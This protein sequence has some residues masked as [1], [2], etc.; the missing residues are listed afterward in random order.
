MDGCKP[1]LSWGKLWCT[2]ILSVSSWTRDYRLM[3]CCRQ[4]SECSVRQQQHCNLQWTFAQWYLLL[5]R[6]VFNIVVK[7]RTMVFA[8]ITLFEATYH[9][10]IFCNKR[11]NPGN[12]NNKISECLAFG[13]QP[14]LLNILTSL[15]LQHVN[16]WQ[17]ISIK[18]IKFWHTKFLWWWVK[19]RSQNKE[20]ALTGIP[21]VYL[22]KSL[23]LFE[24][25]KLW[26]HRSIL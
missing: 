10:Y 21:S 16:M 11:T 20:E 23:S 26:M 13:I 8:L 2:T 12:T 3:K 19:G 22:Y 25:I 1:S 7:Q 6:A 9:T 24:S 18:Q 4:T 17:P 15:S 5:Y 14:W